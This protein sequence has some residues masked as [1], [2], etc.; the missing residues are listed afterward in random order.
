ML[1]AMGAKSRCCFFGEFSQSISSFGMNLFQ[2][3]CLL[4]TISISSMGT[5]FVSGRKKNINTC[6]I[7]THAA[8]NRKR[9]HLKEHNMDR[10]VSRVKK[11]NNKRTN[12]VMLNPADLVSSGKISLGINQANGSHDNALEAMNTN[13]NN[14]KGGASE[15]DKFFP[16]LIPVDSNIA[17]PICI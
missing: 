11:L 10:L 17:S 2:N 5:P 7:A 6:A 16:S 8:K 12:I 13:M 14:S 4:H 1:V 9:P 3:Q 15:C